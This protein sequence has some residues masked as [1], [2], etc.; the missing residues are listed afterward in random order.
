MKAK[1]LLPA[2]LTLLLSVGACQQDDWTGSQPAITT[3]AEATSAIT[4]TLAENVTREQAL[5]VAQT[6][7]VK[8]FP[9]TRSESQSASV[10]EITDGGGSYRYS[11]NGMPCL[12]GT[13][14]ISSGTYYLHMNWGGE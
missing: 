1:H 8:A 11:S 2:L 10:S 4:D 3:E 6:F 9:Q 12:D 14:T 5:E 7:L 13:Y